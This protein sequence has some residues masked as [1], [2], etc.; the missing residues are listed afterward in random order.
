[1]FKTLLNIFIGH[2]N[3]K[4]KAKEKRDRKILSEVSMNM[5]NHR[6]RASDFKT[7]R[8]YQ[9]DVHIMNNDDA[10]VCTR[11]GGRNTPIETYNE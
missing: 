5:D 6:R 2:K 3:L 8:C 9:C 4:E 10:R 1:M 11:C 7:Y